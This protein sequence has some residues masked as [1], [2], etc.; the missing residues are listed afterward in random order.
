MTSL[1]VL[2]PHCLTWIEPHAQCCNECGSV[3]IVDDCDPTPESI[4]DRLGEQLQDLG[5]MKLLRRGWPGCGRL[6]ATTHGLLFVPEFGVLLNGALDAI[7][8]DTQAGSQRVASLFHWWSLPPWKRPVDEP[9]Q[10]HPIANRPPRTMLELL[11]DSPGALFIV[12]NSIQRIHFRWGRVQIER[13]PSRSVSLTQVQGG[14]PPRDTLRQLQE[15]DEWRAL[16]TGL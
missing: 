7:T 15:F 6:L 5:P 14:S 12:R 9:D 13:P 3:V 8:D 2:C 10:K 11:F 1:I 16:V 4:A